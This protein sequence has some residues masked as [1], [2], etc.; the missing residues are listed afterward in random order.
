MIR[1]KDY[2]L[3]MQTVKDNAKEIREKAL[4]YLMVRRTRSEIVR[5]FGDDLEKQG[6][7][8]PEVADPEPVYYELNDEEDAIFVETITCVASGLNYAR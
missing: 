4:K 1:K 6:L 8:F 3:Y 2:E 7:H 5:Y